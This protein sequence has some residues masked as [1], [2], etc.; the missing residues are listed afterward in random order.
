MS[1][2]FEWPDP[3]SFTCNDNTTSVG[4]DAVYAFLRC[5]RDGED[6]LTLHAE[7]KDLAISSGDYNPQRRF[8]NPDVTSEVFRDCVVSTRGLNGIIN[9]IDR[10]HVLL[11][12]HVIEAVLA[13]DDHDL[14]R[15][16]W[17]QR[18]LKRLCISWRID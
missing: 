12:L 2:N 10:S 18:N 6:E 9:H 13:G 16:N 14:L 5:V 3:A 15:A 4:Q 11:N 8:L 7:H 17:S 1:S